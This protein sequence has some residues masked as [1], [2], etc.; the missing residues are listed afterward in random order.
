V[1][2]SV[3]APGGGVGGGGSG[4][5]SGSLA[6][7]GW[8]RVIGQRRACLSSPLPRRVDPSGLFAERGPAVITP[9]G[10]RHSK[11]AAESAGGPA[12]ARK[13]RRLLK[14]GAIGFSRRR[15]GFGDPGRRGRG[16]WAEGPGS[17]AK[18]RACRRA[19]CDCPRTRGR[20]PAPAAP[21][22]MPVCRRPVIRAR[23][24][25]SGPLTTD[26]QTVEILHRAD[27][28]HQRHS[29]QRRGSAAGSGGY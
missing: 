26:P 2:P 23:R 11:P 24:R 29:W 22:T 27:R 20:L 3:A 10:E 21:R 17:C 18:R 19:G 7:S 25:F 28:H 6:G 4:I 15:T 14:T 1:H 9:L 8:W 16:G 5:S 13:G 12:S